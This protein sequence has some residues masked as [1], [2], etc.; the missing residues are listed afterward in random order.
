M[1][2]V[3]AILLVVVVA[4]TVY[5]LRSVTRFFRESMA[6][7]HDLLAQVHACRE[8][9]DAALA[10][11]NRPPP[12]PPEP[13]EM[14]SWVATEEDQARIEQMI[15]SSEDRILSQS[16]SRFSSR[17]LPTSGGKSRRGPSTQQAPR[18]SRS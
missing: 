13:P 3:W 14:Y 9:V 12:P 6:E 7:H 2:M 15:H 5:F 4:E 18:S 16:P 8:R 17:D 1:M 10:I 11:L